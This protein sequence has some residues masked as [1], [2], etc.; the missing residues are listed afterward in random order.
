MLVKTAKDIIISRQIGAKKVIRSFGF[1]FIAA[2]EP[3]D[4]MK[5]AK[6]Q[7]ISDTYGYSRYFLPQTTRLVPIIF[8]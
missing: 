6:K 5:E 3:D 2:V 7:K 1:F 4:W 8:A